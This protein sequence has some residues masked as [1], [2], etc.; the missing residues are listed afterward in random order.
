MENNL[1][2]KG[3]MKDLVR[4]PLGIVAL[5]ISLIYALANLLLG[6]TVSV[7]T[8]HERYPLI[9]FIVLFPVIVLGVF[10][11]LVSKHHG[12]LYAPGDYKDD[13]SFLRTLSPQERQEKLDR[14][15]AEALPEAQPAE[16]AQVVPDPG[17]QTTGSIR[18]F[19]KDAMPSSLAQIYDEIQKTES[20]AVRSL[21][22]E[23]GPAEARDVAIENTGVNFDLLLKRGDKSIFA[24][25]KTLRTPA[26]SSL[27]T[28]DRVLYHAVVADRYFQG[29]FKLIL[30]VV[31]HFEA[32]ELPRIERAWRKQVEK[33]PAEIELRFVPYAE[34]AG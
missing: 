17:E 29:R 25:V 7:L 3:S 20:A 24:E 28:L 15:V 16:Q 32:S 10:Y 13:Q 22:R 9:I 31:Y 12:K 11:R 21:E 33:C 2:S 27:R 6:T 19:T 4:N 14:E 5:F 18:A 23:F 34:I 1:P 26:I 8:E 30:L